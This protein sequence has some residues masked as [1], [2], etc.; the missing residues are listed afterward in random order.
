MARRPRPVTTVLDN[1]LAV[2]AQPMPW[3]DSASVRIAFRA[4]SRYE[5]RETSGIAHFIEHL[6]FQGGERY[7]TPME[8]RGAVEGVGGDV[9]ALTGR[10]TVEYVFTLPARYL[11]SGFD[12]LSDM[13]RSARLD[14]RVIEMEREAILQEFADDD[15]DLLNRADLALRGLLFTD[16]PLSWDVGGTRENIRRFVR[17]DFVRFRRANYV[18]SDAALVVAGDVSSSK[19]FR[20]AERFFGFL[21]ETSLARPAI[22]PCVLLGGSDPVA[23]VALPRQQ[24]FI[25]MGTVAPEGNSA[26]EAACAVL[27]AALGDGT[28]SR[29]YRELRFRRGLVY[30]TDADYTADVDYGLFSLSALTDPKNAVETVSVMAATC[31]SFTR[32]LLSDKERLR[33]KRLIAGGRMRNC[34]SAEHVS[35]YLMVDQLA[36]GAP[37]TFRQYIHEYD[38][39]TSEEV[40]AVARDL[41]RHGRLKLALAGAVTPEM[42]ERIRETIPEFR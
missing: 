16:S 2:V 34:E 15:D 29:L 27:A 13:I 10:E 4:G 39:T 9:N 42:V 17:D 1:G 35:D 32:H 26:Q 11:H 41:L 40:R 6:V 18:A 37:T 22:A 28:A 24:V 36:Y 8:V 31:R 33:A 23:T 38:H 7:R 12:V 20:D 19:V 30:Q 14:H 5:T 21:P 3:L 25:L